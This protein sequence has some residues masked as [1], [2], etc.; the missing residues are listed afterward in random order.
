MVLVKATAGGNLPVDVTVTITNS[1][2][3]ATVSHTSHGMATN[4]KVMIK[5]AS[6][7]ANNGVFTITYISDNSYSYTMSSTPG[8]SPTGTIKATYVALSGT[9]DSNGEI[10]MSRVFSASQPVNGW[11]RKSTSAPFYKPGPISGTISTS[12]D[13]NFSA[14][15]ILDQ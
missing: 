1:G 14:V 4:D 10:T 8:S 3:T 12:A 2:T 13:T 9:T 6:L 5:G 11:A 7:Q 15:L